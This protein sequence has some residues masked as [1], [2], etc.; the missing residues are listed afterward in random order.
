[1]CKHPEKTQSQTGEVST[2]LIS[3]LILRD[4]RSEMRVDDAYRGIVEL[5]PD[6]HAP[7]VTQ[8]AHD[9]RADRFRYHIRN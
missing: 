9:A 5:E 8:L 4:V 1:M 6:G 3:P 2:Y 7:L